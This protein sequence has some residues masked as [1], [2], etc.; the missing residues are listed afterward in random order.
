MMAENV[1]R[2]VDAKKRRLEEKLRKQILLSAISYSEDISFIRDGKIT[3]DTEDLEYIK[4][5]KTVI[6]ETFT[7]IGLT[8][9]EVDTQLNPFFS[10]IEKLIKVYSNLENKDDDPKISELSEN[11]TEED[12]LI[13]L[14]WLSNSPQ[15]N[16]LSRIFNLV[17][18]YISDAE[19]LFNP[20]QEYLNNIN[21]FLADS[22][23]ELFFS[24]RGELT[25]KNQGRPSS[26]LT[27]S[28][29]EKQMV[30]MLTQLSFISQDEKRLF[31]VDEPELS[32]HVRWQE[33]FVEAIMN[34]NKN[35]QIILATHSPSII[36]DQIKYCVDI[37]NR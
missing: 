32:L 12:Q 14:S 31:I 1:Y 10:Q 15:Y 16:R 30:V 7:N 8:K 21:Q 11:F 18:E 20:I 36:L 22:Q 33:L 27:L 26:V 24:D 34:A 13:L 5:R 17:D 23:K 2:N 37:S 28:S 3:I 35:I 19:D 9:K 6:R 29:G 25:V 4:E